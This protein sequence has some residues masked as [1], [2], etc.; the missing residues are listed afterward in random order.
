MTNGYIVYRNG[1]TMYPFSS[2]LYPKWGRV[3]RT[4]GP[5]V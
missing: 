2:I 5:K 1:Y 4:F 3:G